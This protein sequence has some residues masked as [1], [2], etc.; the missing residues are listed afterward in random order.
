MLGLIQA[1]TALLAEGI[2]L[3]MLS[4]QHTVSHCIIHFVALEVIMELSNLYY[5]SLLGNKLKPVLHKAPK[6]EKRGK[7]IKFSERSLF[8]KVARIIYKSVRCL[9][10]GFIF[11][12]VPYVV[13]FLQW[14]LTPSSHH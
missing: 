4:Y 2:N 11:Y 6:V 8:H 7:D 1:S 9:Y 14:F 5:E 3:F 12:F 13:L 10:V